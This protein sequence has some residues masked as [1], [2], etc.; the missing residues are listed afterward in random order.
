MLLSTSLYEN[1]KKLAENNNLANGIMNICS[2]DFSE[3]HIRFI[4][5][6][7]KRELTFLPKG[8]EHIVNDSGNWS[9]KNR[10]SGK[11]GKIFGAI[12]RENKIEFSDS[13]L[14]TFVNKLQG[15]YNIGTFKIVSGDEIAF[16]YNNLC[17]ESSGTLSSSCMQEKPI[18]YFDIY[19]KNEDKVKMLILTD[20]KGF[21]T[22]R[23]IIWAN[24]YMDRIYGS[25]AT[26][27]QFK[28]YAKENN[29]MYKKNQT[30]SDK[31]NFVNEAEDVQYIETKIYLDTDFSNYPYMDTF[32]Y[33][34]DGY[35]ANF[36]HDNGYKTA[37]STCGD[38]E[39]HN[40]V[41]DEVDECYIDE[42]DAIYIESISGYTHV[43]N[44]V[45][46][47]IMSEDILISQSVRISNGDYV[48]SENYGDYDIVYC[49]NDGVYCFTDDSF[50]CDYTDSW[51]CTDNYDYKYIEEFDMTIHCDYIEEFMIS[52]GYEK[53][54][55]NTYAKEVIN[56]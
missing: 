51:Y 39:D 23:A 21:L 1:I 42:D 25:D 45:Y 17:K 16:W 30:F 43:D 40:G 27:E 10:Q 6:N 5:I 9:K 24:L 12:L 33:I 22:G 56:L 50:Y 13:D 37:N 14:E 7:S 3:N 2:N 46:S 54:D 49:E 44:T 8:K 53:I 20:E 35:V 55:G 48:C 34:Y 4:T 47:D 19:A 29:L 36:E 26:I 52:K 18:Y 38:Y 41:Y 32:Q 11:I 28:E 15:L 31:N